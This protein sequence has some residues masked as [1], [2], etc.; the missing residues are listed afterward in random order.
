[1]FIAGKFTLIK[2]AVQQPINELKMWY[3]YAVWY[4]SSQTRMKLCVCM[5]MSG[6]RDYH[7]ERD[8]PN[9]KR[10]VSRLENIPKMLMVMMLMINI[11][12]IMDMNIIG[13]LGDIKRRSGSRK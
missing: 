7:V 4:Y 5:Q 9:L 12:I 1:M 11:V 10:Q 6:S 3:S 8:E 2:Q 13:R